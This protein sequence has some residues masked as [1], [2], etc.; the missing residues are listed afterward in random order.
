MVSEGLDHQ[1]PSWTGP[2]MFLFLPLTMC[3]MSECA[4][5]HDQYLSLLSSVL[6][7]TLTH[8]EDSDMSPQKDVSLRKAEPW[9]FCSF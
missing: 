2:S 8:G 7:Q 9:K 6:V 3:G 5:A 1:W 4:E